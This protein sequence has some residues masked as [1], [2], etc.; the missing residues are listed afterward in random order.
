MRYSIQTKTK[1][2]T[3]TGAAAYILPRAH[4]QRIFAKSR[5]AD[6]R[7]AVCRAAPSPA[8]LP[9]LA[10][11]CA[12]GGQTARAR[13][14]QRLGR[15]HAP[16]RSG[17]FFATAWPWAESRRGPCREQPLAPRSRPPR[18]FPSRP[19][20]L[21]HA[22][23]LPGARPAQTRTPQRHESR[24][25]SRVVAEVAEGGSASK[26]EVARN[27]R[28][29]LP[30]CR[31]G[32]WEARTIKNEVRTRSGRREPHTTMLEPAHAHRDRWQNSGWSN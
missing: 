13:I 22:W 7:E 21:G 26:N 16:C 2:I 20:C 18:C 19:G 15:P 30:A 28:Q 25:L 24:D 8:M 4:A 27:R 5:L 12:A 1:H 9:A 23:P 14:P 6:R 29:S 3:Y 10:L 32:G 17:D 11:V 31:V